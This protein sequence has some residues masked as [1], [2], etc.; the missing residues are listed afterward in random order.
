MNG[1]RQPKNSF[2]R[3]DFT[4]YKIWKESPPGPEQKELERLFSNNQINVMDS[5][6]DIRLK[7][8]IFKD[9]SEKVFLVHFRKTKSKM[10]LNRKYE[11]YYEIWIEIDK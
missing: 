10:G 6:N 7:Y 2:I 1:K 4:P 5:P 3:A 8:P 9:F 11:F